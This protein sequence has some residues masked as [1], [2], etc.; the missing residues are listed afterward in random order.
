M[1]LLTVKIEKPADVNVIFGQAH[2][3][4]SV[5]DIHEALVGAVPGI[6][7]GLAFCEASG[8]ALV[9][10]SGT[11]K[12]MIALAKSNALTIAAGHS[13]LIFLSNAFPINVL[14][15][16]KMVP[17]VCCVFCATANPVEV[18]LA[19]TDQ[20]R[21]VLGVIDGEAPKGVESAGDAAERI[22]LLRKFGYKLG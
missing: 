3:I 21:G 5:E 1:E 11:S 19:E 6:E 10:T 2:F 7:F 8:P 9:R 4:K 16:V 18:V 12:E 13:F 22:G 17:E 14:N 15:A 20:G